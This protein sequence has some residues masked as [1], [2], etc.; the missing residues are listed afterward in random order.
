MV[1]AV[2]SE[3]AWAASRTKDTYLSTKYKKISAR[4][5]KKRAVIAVGHS[6]LRLVYHIISS[7]VRYNELGSDFA[8]KRHTEAAIKRHTQ[9]LI[10]LGVDIPDIASVY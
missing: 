10:N 7:G 1:K 3:C 8:D 9:A 2:L 4:R 5:G 6:I